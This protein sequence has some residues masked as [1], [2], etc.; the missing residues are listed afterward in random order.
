MSWQQFLLI[1][2]IIMLII[3]VVIKNALNLVMFNIRPPFPQIDII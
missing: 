1:M 2:T 3:I